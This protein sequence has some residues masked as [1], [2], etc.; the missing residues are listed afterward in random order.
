MPKYT[1]QVEIFSTDDRE[2]A[3]RRIGQN[4]ARE[5]ELKFQQSEVRQVTFGAGSG[6]AGRLELMRSE[7]SFDNKQDAQDWVEGLQGAP[8]TTTQAVLNA[9]EEPR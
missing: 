2:S 9:D 3:G 4:L 5:L 7:R 8:Q 1:Y 6:M